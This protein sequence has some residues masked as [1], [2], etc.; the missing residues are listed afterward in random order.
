MKRLLKSFLLSSSLLIFLTGCTVLSTSDTSEACSNSNNMC[1]LSICID[2]GNSAR[3]INPVSLKDS[4]ELLTHFV[5]KGV[6][7]STGAELNDGA[8]IDLSSYFT[9]SSNTTAYKIPYGV[10]SLTLEAGDVTHVWLKGKKF[11]DLRT[12][13]E[14]INF[15]LTTENYNDKGSV[16]LGGTY[17][18]AGHVANFCKGEFYSLNNSSLNYPVTVTLS[19]KATPVYSF[20]VDGLTEVSE[21]R[22]SLILKFYDN[23]DEENHK[24]VGYWED[25]VVVA[26]DRKT[27][28][29]DIKCG[30]IINQKPEKPSKLNAYSV[31]DSYITN[32]NGEFFTVRFVWD[33]ASINEEGFVLKIYKCKNDNKPT[34]EGAELYKEYTVQSAS[35]DT[36]FKGGSLGAG[37][38]SCDIQLPC[39]TPFTATIQAQN[40][41]GLSDIREYE[42]DAGNQGNGTKGFA[43]TIWYKP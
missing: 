39:Q 18:D 13:Q 33:D 35:E 2:N 5:L 41:V 19:E 22:Y 32:E 25:I 15:V 38:T 20:T 26:P 27:E 1:L 43:N 10:W 30:P 29:T 23:E 17:L 3:T 11:V 7:T 16:R 34:L 9:E 24:Q 28:D 31:D 14:K 8:G 37:S 36:D 21:G 12:P 6:S 40:F 42:K 4:P